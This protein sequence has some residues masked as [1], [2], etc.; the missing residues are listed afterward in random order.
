[1]LMIQDGARS[2]LSLS[3]KKQRKICMQGANSNFQLR[4]QLH[5]E[6]ILK[7]GNSRPV[8]SFGNRRHRKICIR[9]ANSNFYLGLQLLNEKSLRI[10][11][12]GAGWRKVC[13][14]INIKRYRNWGN[15]HI[16]LKVIFFCNY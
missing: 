16:T 11:I 15:V 14:I 10:N 7:I 6:N 4:V 12:D 2:I 5:K 13:I 9:G 1:M 8:L 3:I